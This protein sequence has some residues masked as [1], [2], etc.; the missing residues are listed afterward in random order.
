MNEEAAKKLVER[1]AQR[2]PVDGQAGIEAA[3]Q[4]VSEVELV[5]APAEGIPEVVS[6][7]WQIE[8]VGRRLAK[9]R[10]PVAF[11]AERA[12]GFTYSQRA[13][14]VQIRREG[15]GSFLVDPVRSGDLSPIDSACQGAEWI[16]HAADQ[17]L[18]CLAQVGM[19]PDQLFDTEVA[20]QLLGLDHIGLA[21]VCEYALGKSLLKDHQ[22]DDWSKRPLPKDWLRYA[23]LDVELLIPLRNKL[24]RALQ[25][26]GKAHWAR[27]EMEAIRTAPPKEAPAEPWR[28]VPGAGKVRTPRG[29]EVLR[30]LWV[31]RDEV[32]R[33]LN[34][35]P[36][37][38]LRNQ[39]MVAASQA[40]ATSRR[41]L[42]SIGA[43]REK[44]ARTRIAIWA[45][46]ARA[47]GRT[48]E[49]A[50]PKKKHSS[51]KGLPGRRQWAKLR[52]GSSERLEIVRFCVHSLADHLNIWQEKLLAPAA[53][54]EL[55]WA[56][57]ESKD[58][59][60]ILEHAGA[61][62]WQV[63]TIASLLDEALATL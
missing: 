15:A 62:P 41:Q 49:S 19:L 21:A 14:L 43:F 55:A 25:L 52:P 61:R 26:A 30:Q 29:L 4:G 17:D 11:D 2:L 28:K 12:S 23:A 7:Y 48:A 46:A 31:E 40:E 37:K 6:E 36:T 39:A 27:Q 5:R 63:E 20:A 1:H 57:N 35:A 60:E 50:L 22:A 10:G 34:I 32:A 45:R 42:L 59:A 3:R 24:S 53:Q 33:E 51:G 13:Y 8:E 16:L 47:A 9:G 54:K 38:I 56:Y 18:P 58:V 44:R